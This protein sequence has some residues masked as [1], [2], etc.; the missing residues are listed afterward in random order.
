MIYISGASSELQ[1]SEVL[2]LYNYRYDV[3]IEHLEWDIVTGFGSTELRIEKDQFDTD[4][5]IYV[6]AKDSQK[7]I[8]GCARL[9]PTTEPYLLKDVFPELLNGM[10]APC[11]SDV[12]ELSRFTSFDRNKPEDLQSPTQFSAETTVQ[13]L[14]K[15]LEVARSYGAKK[16]ITV[17][18][19]AV[20]RLLRRE[21]FSAT[22]LGPPVRSA[23]HLLISCIIDV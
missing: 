6:V 13:L 17:S 3:F 19:V 22:R 9:L 7:Q 20:E 8:V 15:T 1:S 21:N 14:K 10:E 16:L 11:T 18:P 23:G 4:E 5:T 12:W 2:D